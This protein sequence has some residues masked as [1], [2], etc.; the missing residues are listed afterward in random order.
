MRVTLTVF[1][2]SSHCQDGTASRRE[3]D[4]GDFDDDDCDFYG[5]G[6][7][8]KQAVFKSYNLTAL[9]TWQREM[10]HD[11]LI[12]KKGGTNGLILAPTSGGKTL[13]AVIALI[14]TM[15]VGKKDTIL[16]LPYV[17]IVAEK[18]RELKKLATNLQFFTVAEYAGT[19]GRFPIGRRS[20]FIRTL[21]VA[22][23][24]KAN[25]I[26]RFLCK[27][28]NRKEEIGLVIIDEVHMIGD[29]VRGT[30]IEEFVVSLL[31]W[32]QDAV[33]ILALSATIGN[34]MDMKRF[35]GGGDPARCEL[36]H[37]GRRPIN[38]RE[39]MV[40]AGAAFSISRNAE[41]GRA[42]LDYT[43]DGGLGTLLPGDAAIPE[44][45]RIYTSFD[46]RVI[47]D[48]VMTTVKTGGAVLIFCSTRNM[49]VSLCKTLTAAFKYH[50]RYEAIRN[51]HES[52]IRLH[53][54]VYIYRYDFGLNSRGI[55][56]IYIY[57]YKKNY[58][59]ITILTTC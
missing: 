6:Q 33:R 54:N 29:G 2:F 22:T 31:H 59:Y 20:S 11:H 14:H 12:K 1:F 21:Y 50:H 15:L 46:D 10:L 52:W 28:T 40:V 18:V 27:E 48:L 7:D 57:N 42:T 13:V 17:A 43:E 49:C 23:T 35:L 32:S 41:D 9:H 47:A 4:K 51:V 34:A 5:M 55:M 16:A 37:V 44:E 24:E 3:S 25:G 53:D 26:W 30:V 56:N 36:H 39:H 19:K 58:K 8:V 38:I 45:E